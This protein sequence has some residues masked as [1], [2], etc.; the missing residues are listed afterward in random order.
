MDYTSFSSSGRKSV[1][2]DHQLFV[3]WSKC[4]FGQQELDYLGHC[5]SF[6]GGIAAPLTTLLRKDQFGW[7]EDADKAFDHLKKA[8]TTTLVFPNF[9]IPF[10]L[11]CDASGK[12]IGAVL[13][14]EGRPIGFFS[15][16]LSGHNLA[17]STY[18][19]EIAII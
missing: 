3:K 18:E 13:M 10:I 6:N 8:M 15:E 11:E 7:S 5:I 14:Q 2:H 17:L 1:L 4:T 9:S 19:K 16:A 12:G